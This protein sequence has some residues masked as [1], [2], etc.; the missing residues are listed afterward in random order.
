MKILSYLLLSV[1]F[2]STA[3]AAVVEDFDEAEVI[4]NDGVDLLKAEDWAGAENAFLKA[5]EMDCELKYN[6]YMGIGKSRTGLGRYDDAIAAYEEALGIKETYIAYRALADAELKAGDSGGFIENMK[7]AVALDDGVSDGREAEADILMFRAYI[8]AGDIE[9]R[10]SDPGAAISYYDIA[11]VYGVDECLAHKK[12]GIAY[13]ELGDDENALAHLLEVAKSGEADPDN[14]DPGIYLRLGNIYFARGDTE[15]AIIDYNKGLLL[16]SDDDEITELLNTN[17][18]IAE[19]ALAENQE[20]K[21][22]SAENVNAAADLVNSGNRFLTS[23]DNEAAIDNYIKAR[24]LNPYAYFAWYNAAV[25]YLRLQDY[26]LS[27]DNLLRAIEVD[28]GKGD[29]Y[30][31]YARIS[32]FSGEEDTAAEYLYKAIDVDPKYEVD[33]KKDTVLKGII[34]GDGVK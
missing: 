29:A 9:I 27:L 1:F 26:E 16:P 24:E 34:D 28:P 22:I 23:G 6:A 11:L 12:L 15:K 3:I 18:A 14:A 2:S 21:G 7:K 4:Y 8:A 19:K 25:A 13:G 5:L 10:A 32:A 30:Y 33:A 17:K 20:R 31:L